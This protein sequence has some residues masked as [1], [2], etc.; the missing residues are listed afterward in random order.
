M[1]PFMQGAE[2]LK[3]LLAVARGD[4]PADLV[5]TGGQLVNVFTGEIYPAEVAI[6]GDR[7]AGVSPSPGT[8]TGK[9]TL[10]LA[11][12]YIAPGFMDAHVHIE[13]SMLLPAEYANAVLPHGTTAV[14]T[15]PHEIANV[16][17]VEGVRF[18]LQASEGLPL[19]VFVMLS[20]C[21]PATDMETSGARLGVEDLAALKNEPRV[22]GI[23]EMMNYP[24]VAYGSDDMV[25]KVLL[26]HGERKR[27]DG[28]APLVGGSMLQAYAAAGV[29]SDHESVSAEEALQKLRAGM[30]VHIREGSTARNLDALLPL[31]TT[32]NSRF[33]SWATDD[34]QP[35]DLETQGHI[36]HNIR[37]AIKQ[38]L[39]PIVAI[40]MATINTARHYG[41]NDMGAVA[42][43]YVADLVTFADL[44]NIRVSST[45]AGGRLVAE[46]GRMLEPLVNKVAPPVRGLLPPQLS[47]ASFRIPAAGRQARII[48]AL[49][50]QIV[51]QECT[52]EVSADDGW[53]MPD[54]GRDILKLAVVERHAGTGNVGLGFVRG[55]QMKAGALASSVA[56]D[57][58]NVVVVGTNDRDMLLAAEAVIEM[59]GGLSAARDGE[60]LARLALPVAGLM[61]DQPLGP[62][63]DALLVLLQKARELGCPLSNPY[64][65]MAFLALPVI[66]ALKLTDKGLVDVHK[67]SLVRLFVS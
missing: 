36:D 19:H 22:L 38:G 40:Q 21:V 32:A 9:Q 50:D 3:T 57:S 6:V 25:G 24:G 52:A 23:A 33:C 44:R 34:K 11:G 51:T 29:T 47:E 4:A 54:L 67:F 59:G 5:L 62:V 56:H 39:D 20:S 37:Q 1:K 26:G 48:V 45:F 49:P 27:V 16:Y 43:G 18:M 41:L 2:S 61:S 55:F 46:A 7:V 64:M 63:R 15:D 14:V 30:H 31:V 13:S 35:D 28:H 53:A 17:G 10:E 8:Y 60:V 12:E 42:P 58:H 65:A 66:P